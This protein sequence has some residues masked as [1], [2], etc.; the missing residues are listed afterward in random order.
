MIDVLIVPSLWHDPLPRVVYESYSH[1]VPVIGSDRGGI[2]EIIDI[3]KTGFIFNPD[4]EEQLKEKICIFR[5][6][7]TIIKSMSFYC[8]EKARDFLPEMVVRK[9]TDIYRK[10]K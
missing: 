8:I 5:K 2:P 3:G 9:Y 4:F 1:G 7:P 10:I 6:D